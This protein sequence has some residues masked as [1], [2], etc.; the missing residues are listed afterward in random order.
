MTSDS[1]E[2]LVGIGQLRKEPPSADEL[3]GLETGHWRVLAKVHA[4]RNTAE[5]EGYW[6]RT[7]CCWRT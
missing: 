6:S 7:S 5:Y 1:L 4:T 2:N 3:A